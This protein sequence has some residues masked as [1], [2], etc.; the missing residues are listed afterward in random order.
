MNI[1][2]E[3]KYTIITSVIDN[4][5]KTPFSGKDLLITSANIGKMHGINI[6]ANDVLR[7]VADLY[8]SFEIN[9]IISED[10]SVRFAKSLMYGYEENKVSSR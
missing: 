6:N 8:D 2:F 9:R 1:E 4:Y 10:G 5:G 7:V 3:K